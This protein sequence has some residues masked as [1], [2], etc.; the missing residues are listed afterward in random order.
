MIS[1]HPLLRVNRRLLDQPEFFDLAA[2]PEGF[3]N[4][5]GVFL[6]VEHLGFENVEGSIV[7]TVATFPAPMWYESH[8]TR[9]IEVARGVGVEHAQDVDF[10]G[11]S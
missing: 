3:L 1:T 10:A 8:S 5:L 9:G 4:C 6:V 2:K 11:I 7:P